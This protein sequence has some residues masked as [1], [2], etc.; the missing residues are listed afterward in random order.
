MLKWREPRKPPRTT[1]AAAQ[2]S[3]QTKQLRAAT[4]PQAVEQDRATQAAEL[5][6]AEHAAE[7]ATARETAAASPNALFRRRLPPPRCARATVL[8]D[9]RAAGWRVAPLPRVPAADGC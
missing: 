6:R 9:P 8:S 1:Q 5:G 3:R 2:A 4:K 7:R